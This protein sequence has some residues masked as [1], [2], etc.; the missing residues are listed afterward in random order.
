MSIITTGTVKWFNDS[1]GVGCIEQKQGSDIFVHFKQ[2]LDSNGYSSRRRMLIS[3]QRVQFKIARSIKGLQAE[4][5][6]AI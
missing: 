4:E 1:T 3:G 2:I 6:T 5:V